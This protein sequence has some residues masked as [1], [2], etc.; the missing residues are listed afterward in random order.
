MEA[1]VLIKTRSRCNTPLLPDLKADKSRWR[2]VHDL[3]AVN[4]VVRSWP[5]VI[6]NPHTLLTNVPP[7]AAYFSV[8]DL[9]SALFSVS[10]ADQCQYLFAFTYRGVRYTYNRMPQGF[11]HSPRVFN[12]VLKAYP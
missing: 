4:E 2:L 9:C 11:K 3:G 12:Q 7:E 8:I 1:G 5:A 6:P 10:L